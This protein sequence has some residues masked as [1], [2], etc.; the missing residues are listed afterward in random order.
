LIDVVLTGL[1]IVTAA[2]ASGITTPIAVREQTG[3][4]TK[5]KWYCWRFF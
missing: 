3:N 5:R 2:L 1:M 4:V